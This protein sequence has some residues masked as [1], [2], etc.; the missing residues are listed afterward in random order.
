[1]DNTTTFSSYS[2]HKS[3]ATAKLPGTSSWET[4]SIVA[5]SPSKSYSSYLPW[6]F[7]DPKM[8]SCSEATTNADSSP[9]TSILEYSVLIYL[10]RP[11]QIQPRCLRP[12]NGAF[13]RTAY[14]LSYQQEIPL[15]PRRYL[16]W[17]QNSTMDSIQL[18][19]IARID[20]FR[21]VPKSGLFCDLVWA[22]PVDNKTGYTDQPIKHNDVRGCSY[23]F[24][25]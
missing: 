14:R 24:G 3:E 18:D 22:D 11:I 5:T 16:S 9:P 17:T 21:E 19:D 10:L 4:M 23:F 13:W 12:Y 15:C 8:S 2:R 20:R 1:M 25:S 7:Q 6:K